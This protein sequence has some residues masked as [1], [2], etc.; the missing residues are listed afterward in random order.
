MFYD[1]PGLDG[2]VRLDPPK[3]VKYAKPW[4]NGNTG[5]IQPPVSH[6]GLQ[7]LE[8]ELGA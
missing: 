3:R 1:S 5:Q 4:V 7:K 6:D 8:A 2:G